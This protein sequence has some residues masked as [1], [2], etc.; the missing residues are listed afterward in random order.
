MSLPCFVQTAA[1]R[2]EE[3][4]V[5]V[6]GAPPGIYACAYRPLAA[7]LALLAEGRLALAAGNFSA[8][9]ARDRSSCAFCHSASLF[10]VEASAPVPAAQWPV[11][12]DKS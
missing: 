10:D 2:I 3:D 4:I 8:A 5:T 12:R 9:E 11:F 7:I 6:P 1:A